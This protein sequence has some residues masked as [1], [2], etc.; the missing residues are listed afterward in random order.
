M[1]PQVTDGLEHITHEQSYSIR[2]QKK[3]QPV[4]KKWDPLVE[5]ALYRAVLTDQSLVTSHSALFL[6]REF[7]Q[8]SLAL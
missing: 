6:T 8:G 5:L 2:R 3:S 1:C 4:T 7:E